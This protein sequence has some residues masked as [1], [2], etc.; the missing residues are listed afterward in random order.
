MTDTVTH[1]KERADLC[2][3]VAACY[4]EPTEVFVEEKLF[5]SMTTAASAVSPEM[6]EAAEP[7]GKLFL[8]EGYENLLIDYSRLFLGPNNTL[9]QPYG[10]VWLDK[11]KKLMQDSTV[12]VLELYKEGGFELSEDFRELPDHIAAEL[13][14]LYLLIYRESEALAKAEGT[15][16]E[17]VRQLRQRFLNDHLGRWIEPFTL[18]IE[19]GAQTQFYGRVANLTRVFVGAEMLRRTG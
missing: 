3:F 4:Y 19:A 11:E 2:R 16:A 5:D 9:A 6:G 17:A 15:R 14:F 12:Q 8:S 1:A 18:A 13:E 10:S 7:L